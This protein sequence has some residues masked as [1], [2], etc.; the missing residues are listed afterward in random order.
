MSKKIGKKIAAN[1]AFGLCLSPVLAFAQNVPQTINKDTNYWPAAQYD[2][3]VPTLKQVLGYEHGEKIT[4]P[5]DI[6][7]YLEALQKFAPDRVVIKDYGKTWEGRRLVYVF[8]GSRENISRL[9]EIRVNSVALADPRKTSIAQKNAIIANQPVIIWYTNSV[10]GDEISGA[11]ASLK[12]A[13]HILAV[14]N[15]PKYDEIRKNSLVAIVPSQNPDGRERF[16][17]SNLQATG[18]NPNTDEFAAERDQPWPGGRMNHYNFDLNRDWFALT[19][20]ET[21][22]QT[23]AFLEYYPQVVVDAHEMGRDGNFFFPPEAEPINQTHT[24][25]QKDLRAIF[26]AGNAKWFDRFG[27]NY[28]TR[29]VYDGFYPGYGDSWPTSQGAIA[30]TY[31]QASARGLAAIGKDGNVLT[32]KDTVKN[33]FI[34]SLATIETA[35]LNRAR[36][37]NSFYEFRK[38]AISEAEKAPVKS[39]IIPTQTN[40]SGADK[41]AAVLARQ[42]IEIGQANSSFSA[43]GNDFAAGSYIIARGQPAGRL[44]YNLLERNVPLETNFAKKQYKLRERGQD[45]EIYDVTAWSLPLLY[46][47][48]VKTCNI[49]P[50]VSQSA[51]SKDFI[52]QGSVDKN[53]PQ[54][55]FVIEAANNAF[56]R[57]VAQGLNNGLKM[58]AI[59]EDFAIDGKDYK[60]GSIVVL[61]NENDENYEIKVSNIAQ[62]TGAKAIGLDDSWVTKGPS[63][64]SIK[65][66]RLKLPKIA[67]AW[68]FPTSPYSAGNTRFALEQKIGLNVTPLRVSRLKSP[69]IDRFDVIILPDTN[70]DYSSYLGEGGI[71]NLK[72]FVVNGGVVI[73]LGGAT[74]FM[75]SERSGLINTK[76]ETIKNPKKDDKAQEINDEK[77]YL[78]AI[79]PEDNA[80]VEIHGVILKVKKGE[81]HWLT[82]GLPND[83]YVMYQGNAIYSPLTRDQGENPLYFAPKE[84]IV[85]G[86]LIWEENKAR[87]AYKP[88]AMVA[89]KGRGFAIGFNADIT[90]RAHTDGLDELLLNAILQ[91]SARASKN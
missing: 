70:G 61:K 16:L 19:Q 30:M 69:N 76:I 2:E 65:S 58:R 23:K 85:G 11:D 53:N 36:I 89:K 6:I 72:Q 34:A 44:V 40:I 28:F 22:G 29:E 78:D 55:G 86:G 66:V 81:D 73:G 71:N 13:Y 74:R 37:L 27:I 47:L 12:L 87:L 7:K 26:G 4:N 62:K 17:A 24:Q 41:L 42:G 75:A 82:Q 15:D 51:A 21:Q 49:V 67:I 56:N 39:Y 10:H 88:F 31:E 32:F 33:H 43:C 1:L 52:K 46:N 38:S 90:Y 25:E 20:P 45:D 48:E 63:F 80:P 18:A 84:E 64:G 14:K 60:S 9:D 3:N 91:S 35:A 83:L 79:K 77:S 59:S 50:N 57:F 5:S 8:V 54:V 68:D